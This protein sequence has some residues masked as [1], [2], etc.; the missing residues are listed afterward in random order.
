[1]P[2]LLINGNRLVVERGGDGLP[3]VLVHGS[4]TGRAVWNAV[5]EIL[6]ERFDVTAYDRLGYNGSDRPASPY[7]RRRHEDDLIALIEHLDAGPVRSSATPTAAHLARRRRAAPGP[8][9]RR[10]GP[11]AG[12]DRAR[13][14]RRRAVAALARPSAPSPPASEPATTRQRRTVLRG[15]RARPGGLGMLPDVW[16]CDHNAPTFAA[17]TERLDARSTPTPI[18]AY[19]GRILM[20]QGA[21]SPAWFPRD[22]R[23]GRRV[24]IP[25]AERVVMP[26]RRATARTTPTPPSSPRWSRRTSAAGAAAQ[27]A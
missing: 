14:P 17:E 20:T 9:P 19:D 24:G 10:R 8:R 12:A 1:M 15:D 7:T 2:S 16:G 18:P 6:R 5:A 13:R 22:R 11:R 26:G 23:R 3:L 25:H 21:L 4:W 27:A